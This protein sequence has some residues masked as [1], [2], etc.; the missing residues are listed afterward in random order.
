MVYKRR[1]EEVASVRERIIAQLDG[2]LKLLFDFWSLI[3]YDMNNAD[4]FIKKTAL[5]AR[6]IEFVIIVSMLRKVE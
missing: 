5:T 1:N 4:I 3:Q 2:F 6:L